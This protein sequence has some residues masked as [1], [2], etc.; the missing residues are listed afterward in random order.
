MSFVQ[1]TVAQCDVCGHEWLARLG[2]VY[3]HCTSSKCRSRK[4]NQ[5]ELEGSSIETVLPSM[6]L[7]AGSDSSR[8][9]QE[10]LNQVERVV[11]LD[12]YIYEETLCE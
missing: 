1:R 12:A 8:P 3:T 7:K 11:E 9:G 6:R 5:S 2:V 4:W 10:S